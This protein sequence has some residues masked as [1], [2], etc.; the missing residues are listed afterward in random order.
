[1]PGVKLKE[2]A[3]RVALRDRHKSW[4]Q[5]G[6]EAEQAKHAQKVPRSKGRRSRTRKQRAA[7]SRRHIPELSSLPRNLVIKDIHPVEDEN[8]KREKER[9]RSI[10]RGGGATAAPPFDSRFT[11]RQVP[12]RT[13]SVP[14]L[15]NGET[16]EDANAAV[17]GTT[18]STY[19]RANEKMPNRKPSG[20]HSD[21]NF[22]TGKRPT[23]LSKA[24]PTSIVRRHASG[25]RRSAALP[26]SS[27]MSSQMSAAMS[28]GG[29]YTRS[30]PKIYGATDSTYHPQFGA[31]SSPADAAIFAVQTT[32]REKAISAVEMGRVQYPRKAL[33]SPIK[34]STT[35]ENNKGH[36]AAAE[37]GKQL[38]QIAQNIPTPAPHSLDMVA[39]DLQKA[40]LWPDHIG[41]R[42][43]WPEKQ[44]TST[45]LGMLADQIRGASTFAPTILSKQEF[46]QRLGRA[47]RLGD[48]DVVASLL[49]ERHALE[50][51]NLPGEEGA[52]ALHEAVAGCAVEIVQDLLLPSGADPTTEVDFLGTPLDVARNR[53]DRLRRTAPANKL[54][55]QEPKFELLVCLLQTTNIWQASL[56]GD[57]A[58]VKHLLDFDQMDVN[59]QNPY[60]CTPLHYACMSATPK[61]IELLLNRGAYVHVKNKIGQKPEDVSEEA[62]VADAL[63]RESRERKER[64]RERA[65][66]RRAVAKIRD[67]R[68]K[69]DRN[70]W[71]S[72][73]GTSA[74]VPL[75]KRL[76]EHAKHR[77]RAGRGGGS[78]KRGVFNSKTK[79]GRY[80]LARPGSAHNTTAI[81]RR[82]L[83]S[84]R[85]LDPVK[86]ALQGTS[87]LRHV[88]DLS[89]GKDSPSVVFDQFWRW[90]K[91]KASRRRNVH[92]KSKG[93]AAGSA[94]KGNISR[95]PKSA[96]AVP[97]HP[98]VD[99]QEFA[100]WL[101][102]HFGT[103]VPMERPSQLG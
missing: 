7:G 71:A 58:R 51:I 32:P 45:A 37:F 68:E 60:G 95:R 81:A 78:Q 24:S 75:A 77:K 73:R 86:S 38:Q 6:L 43:H 16:T 11:G 72:V 88:R 97:G 79:P 47:C 20:R 50:W 101:R 19:R 15:R 64:K 14:A 69:E 22:N 10:R 55:E 67:E 9:A 27:S 53:L 12:C 100:K 46:V 62:W 44:E 48:A 82:S 18:K 5:R 21:D 66:H 13:L 76:Q 8:T 36:Q 23:F 49:E 2:T 54:R 1:M 83:P 98:R 33:S 52:T 103:A 4:W 35:S 94:G 3:T 17:F 93:G 39:P 29:P 102:L 63:A 42:A 31:L 34:S 96:I 91:K 87:R 70:A 25:R 99:S 59:A 65:E 28:L 40:V 30:D 56:E 90:D 80:L 89:H 92:V 84:D 61:V 41:E 74:A 85:I 26:S 57:Y